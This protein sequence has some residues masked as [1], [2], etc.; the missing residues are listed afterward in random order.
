MT[1]LLTRKIVSNNKIHNKQNGMDFHA[2]L[3]LSTLELTE[4]ISVKAFCG[5][6]FTNINSDNSSRQYF[7]FA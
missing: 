4:N 7:I 1:S 5:N 2:W 3:H 6:D